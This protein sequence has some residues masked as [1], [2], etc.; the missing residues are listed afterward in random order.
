MPLYRL[1]FE[2]SPN[3]ILEEKKKKKEKK[4]KIRNSDKSFIPINLRN[5]SSG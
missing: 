2:C 3:K 1:S 5:R 4:K